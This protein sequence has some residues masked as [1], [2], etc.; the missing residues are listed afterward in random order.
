[1][2]LMEGTAALAPTANPVS[3]M[4]G[5]K[6]HVIRLAEVIQNITAVTAPSSLAAEPRGAPKSG[7]TR[8]ALA[9]LFGEAGP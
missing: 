9:L 7:V 1:M 5:G 3:H 2:T 8:N 4:I 6:L